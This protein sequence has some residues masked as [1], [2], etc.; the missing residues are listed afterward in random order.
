MF[1]RAA[2]YELDVALPIISVSGVLR[3]VAVSTVTAST[4]FTPAAWTSL[5]PRAGAVA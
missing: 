4:R 1:S 2:N 5:Q 3:H